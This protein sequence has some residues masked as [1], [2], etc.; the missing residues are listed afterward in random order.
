MVNSRITLEYER[1]RSGVIVPK[2]N[3]TEFSYR[4]NKKSLFKKYAHLVTGFANHEL[5]RNYLGIPNFKEQVSLLVPNGYHLKTKYGTGLATF[6]SRSIYADKLSKILT[7][8][9]LLLPYINDYQEALDYIFWGV[10]IVNRNKPIP[11]LAHAISFTTDTFYPDPNPETS[12]VDGYIYYNNANQS[13]AT[14]RNAATGSGIDGNLG[15]DVICRITAGTSSNTWSQFVRA[16]YLFDTSSIPD[17]N[18]VSSATFSLNGTATWTENSFSDSVSL[19]SS[20]PASNTALVAADYDQ[21]GTTKFASDI[22]MASWNTSGYNDFALNATGIAAI[23]KTG[24]TKF[25]VRNTSDNDNAEPTWSSG[26]KSEIS[27][28]YAEATGT[29]TDPKLVATHDT[30]TSTTTST[31]TTTTSTSSSTTTSTTTTSTSTS[32][33]TSTTTTTTST[34]TT[35]SSSTSTTTT[36]SVTTSTSTTT[37]TTSTSTT[38]SSSTSSS[39]TVTIPLEIIVD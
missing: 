24:I 25:G 4:T 30:T 1:T 35:T 37:T 19:V 18:T 16:M 9:D 32:S 29:S 15:D 22:A 33:S 8:I 12:T 17:G 39:T 27:G 13:W 10:G 36:V 34:S 26:A 20:A 7:E 6:Y 3:S 21:F 2:N 23:S 5:G 28:N 31:S 38:T 14:L 11:R